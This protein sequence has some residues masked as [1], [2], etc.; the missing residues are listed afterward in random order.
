M[1]FAGV[2][3]CEA[4]PS[5]APPKPAARPELV[6][7]ESF[8]LGETFDDVLTSTAAAEFSAFSIRECLDDLAI[9]GCSLDEDN[10]KVS[11]D[12]R[13][14]IPY[15]RGFRFNRRGRLTDISVHYRRRGDIS[16]GECIDVFERTLD[17]ASRL[18]GPLISRQSA[19]PPSSMRTLHSPEGRPYTTLI[20]SKDRSFVTGFMWDAATAAEAKLSG[21]RYQFRRRHVS[22]LGAFTV[23]GD[24]D[25][26]VT[27]YISEPDSV[28]RA[29]ERDLNNDGMSEE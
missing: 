26:D 19:D 27:L 9:R 16:G 6:G 17:W 7:Y 2:G 23:S 28:E 18:Y 24:A 20:P 25:C 12:R 13:D 10:E 14:G 1:L 8:K 3:G 22:L 11:I 4:A 21:G 29:K 5:K 15:F